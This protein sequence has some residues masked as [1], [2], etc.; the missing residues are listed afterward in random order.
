GSDL[1]VEAVSRVEAVD[2]RGI[3]AA[4]L[5]LGLPVELQGDLRSAPRAGG[6]SLLAASDHAERD[7]EG[8]HHDCSEQVSHPSHRFTPPYRSFTRRIPT[9]ASGGAPAGCRN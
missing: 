8:G 7:G 5:R 3:E 9:H 6:S 1:H 4:E 2:L